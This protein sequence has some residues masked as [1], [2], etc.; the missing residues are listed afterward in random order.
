[1]LITGFHSK[2]TS[3]NISS[4]PIILEGRSWKMIGQV[5]S[6]KRR[7]LR[8][9]HLQTLRG[10]NPSKIPNIWGQADEKV[11]GT[12]IHIWLQDLELWFPHH[13]YIF[14]SK[15][16]TTSQTQSPKKWS[17]IC[18]LALRIPTLNIYL[19]FQIIGLPKVWWQRRVRKGKLRHI[20][21]LLWWLRQ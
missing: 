9:T 1:M 11:K 7:T 12:L 16:F 2:I 10:M 13:L 14:F 6:E 21:G 8:L 4:Y 3:L 15:L 17:L 5:K 20:I 18:T 19:P